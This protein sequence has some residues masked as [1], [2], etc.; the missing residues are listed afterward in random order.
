M[1]FDSY[2]E[3]PKRSHLLNDFDAIRTA[4]EETKTTTRCY[5][6]IKYHSQ[7]VISSAVSCLTSLNII[8][9]GTRRDMI[10]PQSNPENACEIQILNL[11]TALKDLT[12]TYEL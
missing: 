11:N 4:I 5:H 6:T 9:L 12:D 10:R 2:F 1:D 3:V 8:F 7:K